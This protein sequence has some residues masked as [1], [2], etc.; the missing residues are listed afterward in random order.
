MSDHTAPR[1]GATPL[2]TDEHMT[3]ETLSAY[4]N[5]ALRLN[6]RQSLERHLLVCQD[7]RRDLAEAADL[8]LPNVKR[9]WMLV[10]APLAAA[11]VFALVI[12]RPFGGPTDQTSP[13]LRGPQVEG[14][15]TFSAVLP[16][17]GESV[18]IDSLV[19]HWRSAAPE[20]HYAFT[21]TDRNG[22]VVYLS[23]TAD[24]T[25]TLPR[26]V[27]LEPAARYFWYVDAL[28]EGARSSTTGV[29]EFRVR[30]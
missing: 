25:L 7:C 17:E 10:G 8:G 26:S 11:A 15:A 20:A 24:T 23:G 12:V 9:R 29:R 30:P 22:D 6:E 13:V 2:T 28:L 16:A 14:R 27:G 3:P 21:L 1:G 5:G 19:F 18:R 4:L